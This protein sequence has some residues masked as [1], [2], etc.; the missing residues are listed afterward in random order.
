M[1]IKGTHS[2]LHDSN[3]Q[4]VLDTRVHGRELKYIAMEHFKKT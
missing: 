2:L 1:L 4:I 3:K